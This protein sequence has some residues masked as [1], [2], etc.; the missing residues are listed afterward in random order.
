M[1]RE[2]GRRGEWPP[3]TVKPSPRISTTAYR[4]PP[5]CYPAGLGRAEVPCLSPS[6]F[7]K[8]A[9]S[10]TLGNQPLPE[11]SEDCCRFSRLRASLF[12]SSYCLQKRYHRIIIMGFV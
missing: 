10:R 2:K 6:E 5:F 1:C 11:E 9:S 7:R 8:K 3:N 4:W 12:N